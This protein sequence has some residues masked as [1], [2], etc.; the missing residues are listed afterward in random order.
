LSKSTKIE[1]RRAPMNSTTGLALASRWRD[2]GLSLAAFG[3][4][5][6]IS[7]DVVKYWAN[8]SKGTSAL[9]ERGGFF[10]LQPEAERRVEVD[11]QSE[12]QE[13]VVVMVVP[14]AG[15]ALRTTLEAVGLVGRR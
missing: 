14:A 2:S 3:R 8:K 12:T 9:Q 1:R 10:V 4:Q 15:P 7:A 6:G 11:A 5:E 13:H